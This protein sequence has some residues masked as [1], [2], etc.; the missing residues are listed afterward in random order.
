MPVNTLEELFEHE[1]Q[2]IY[3]AEHELLDV[4]EEL[5][6][7][8]E[9][10]EIAQAFRDHREETEHHVE[11]VE[12][13]FDMI[14][15]PPEE[16]EC[17]GIEGLVEE[18]DQFMNRSPDQAIADVYNLT[19]AQKTEHYEIAAYG[20]LALL[21]DRLG[22]DEAGDLL[23][24]NLEEEEDALDTLATLTEEHDYAQLMD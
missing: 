12:Q 10:E 17:K 2:D 8:T 4:L 13:V 3:F 11:R 1:L 24:E 15:E 21:A 5:A 22:M 19:A 23:H 16:A 14:G 20:N 18:H 7:Q 9:D 6:E